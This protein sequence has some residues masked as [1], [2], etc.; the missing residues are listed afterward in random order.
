MRKYSVL[1]ALGLLSML[2]ISLQLSASPAPTP[3]IKA[4]VNIDPQVFNPNRRGAITAY[5]SNLTKDGV[6]YNVRDANISTIK[7][8]HEGI[9]VANLLRG[10]VEDNTLVVKFDAKIVADYIWSIIYHMGTIPPQANYTMEFTV[11]GK[12]FNGE[13]FAGSDT[14]KIVVLP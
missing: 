12:L 11:V 8:Y 6:S 10:K 9:F 7:L 13:Q 2:L 14:I 4:E 1:M 3:T 5:I